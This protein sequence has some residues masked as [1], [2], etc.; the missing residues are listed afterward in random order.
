MNKYYKTLELDKILEMLSKETSN[1]DSAK[2]ALSLEPLTDCET[3]KNEVRKTAQTLDLCVK[4]GTP[5]FIRFKDIRPALKRA[6]SGAN[7]SL[8]ELLDISAM[9]G[10]IQILS[11]WYAH[12]ENTETELDYLFSRVMPN[13]YL[14]ERI[15]TCIISEDEIA[16]TAS[17]ELALIRRKITQ[18][19]IKLRDTLDK[20]IRSSNVQKCL[21]ENLITL[22]DGRY[23]LPV[24]AEHKNEIK[25]LIHDTSATG[26]TIFIEPMS[27]V[28]AN[29]DIRLLQSKEQEEIERIIAELS[30]DC[31]TYAETIKDGYEVCVEL[32]V[33]FAKANLGA[34]MK[35]CEPEISDDGIL[36]LNK[37]RH[38][39]LDKNKAV[40]IS[41]SLGDGYS[42][43][44]IT[45]PN[46]GGKTV[47]LKTAGL[48]TAMTMCGL[49]IPASDGSR[50]SV[51][52][53]ILVDIGDQ[54]SIENNLST[55]SAHTN[56]V[57]E[58]LRI[59]NEKS[60]VLIDELGSGTDPVEGSAL[61]VAVLEKLKSE[62]AKIM[63][64]TH[65]Q[66]L[67]LYA[68]E[69]DGV[70]N[71]SCE[72]DIETL[73]PTYKL[74]VG[75]PGK[76]NAFAISSLLGMPSD[77]I[78]H[79]KSLVD[80]QNTRFEQAVEELDK[81]R[82]EL[83]KQNEEVRRLKNEIAE[84]EKTLR[85]QLD[86]LQKNKADE[87][88]RA[89]IQ[90]M[91]IIEETKSQSNQLIDELEKLKKEKDRQDFSTSVTGMRSRSKRAFNKM[92]DTA[93]PISE[94]DRNAGYVLPRELKAGDKVY[95]V[96][97]DKN[98]IVTKESDDNGNI[99]VQV[100]IMK[101]KI[102]ITRVRLIENENVTYQG[103]PVP[104]Q[105]KQRPLP[106][107]KSGI[108]SR[109]TRKAETEL[110]IR[111]CSANEGIMEVDRFINNAVLCGMG[112][113][114][115][116]HGRGT[117]IL[118]KAVHQRLKQLSVVKSFRLGVYGEGE[119]GVTVVELN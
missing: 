9:L 92:Y 68:V 118:R 20:M 39:L 112:I 85:L 74:I 70:Q 98:G 90:A 97:L 43:L 115:I 109:V 54:Q 46:T 63:V 69:Q 111:G 50:I 94:D 89:R 101:M 27:V 66:E 86:E 116:I 82:A 99:F 67:K 58:I 45:G 3:V 14:K 31:A 5:S 52:E 59:A 56:K 117:G 17:S 25:G 10:Q 8:R 26:Q 113:V 88:E 104:K 77:V 4:F 53:N 19:G 34:K 15:D 38:P 78:E 65:Y 84:K 24:R 103:K 1:E 32:N 49:L 16:D 83:D 87:L 13:K 79:A 2:L 28:E 72:F 107:Q 100:G 21:Q 23:V 108:E 110:D 11:D 80:S 119:D 64:T 7:L 44:I 55:F 106:R 42:M 18:A 29:N 73:K 35:A 76:S 40:P 51:F 48:L 81:S 30:K 61:A 60:L 12:C 22:R 91:R 62:N 75:S 33:Y 41:F 71:A 57:I 114:T 96:D 95:L 37:A 105:K 6:S 36:V 47:A 93:N 102:S